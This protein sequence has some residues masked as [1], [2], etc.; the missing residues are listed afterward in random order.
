M[1]DIRSQ[2]R[3]R[4][5]PLNLA[6]AREAEV[7]EELA[8]HLQ[9]RFDEKIAAGMTEADAAGD[10]AQQIQQLTRELAEVERRQPTPP[11]LAAPRGRSVLGT[12]WQDTRFALR[13]FRSSPGVAAIV[14]LTLALGIGATTAVFSVLDVVLLRPMPY[15]DVDRIVRVLE[16]TTEGRMMSVSWPNYLDWRERNR[17]FEH[18]GISRGTTANLTGREQPERLV[19]ASVS[20]DLFSVMGVPPLYGRAFGPAED[21][22]SANRVAIISERLWRSHFGADPSV[23]GTNVSLDGQMYALVG[24]MPAAM[25]YP[26]RLTDLWLPIGL[27][28]AA[29]PPRGAH[30]GLTGMGKLKPGVTLTQAMADMESVALQLEQQYPDSNKN[31]RVSLAS[32]EDLMVRNIRPVLLVLLGAVGCV[33]LIGCANLAN[34]LLSRG[35]DRHREIAIRT[36]LGAERRRIVQ[37]LLTESLL[38]AF[39]GGALGAGLAWWA[40]RAF[41]ASQPSTVPRIDVVSVDGRVLLFAAALSMITG[42]VF[43]LVPALRASAP[44]L[45]H[46]IKDAS[47]GTTARSRRLR[48]ALVVVEVALAMVLLVGAGLMIRSFGKLMNIDPGF[49]AAHVI[50]GRVTLP[51]ARYPDVAAWQRF[52]RD[53]IERIQAV[54]GIDAAAVNT[55]MPLEGGA[56]ESSV[57]AEGQPRPQ[58]GRPGHSTLFQAASPDYFRTMGIPIVKGRALTARDTKDAPYVVV[59]DESFAAKLF[60]SADPIGKRIAFETRGR[61]PD[62]PPIWREVVGVVG[63]VKHHG[64]VNEPP[65]VQLYTSLDQP[66]V[67]WETRG[68]SIAVFVRSALAPP[69]V[70]S[71]LRRELAGLDR[72]VPIYD[73][74]PMNVLVALHVE[75]QRLSTMLLAGLGGLALVLAIV[76][77]YGVLSYAVA[78]RTQEL[79]IRMALGASRAGVLALVIRHGVLLALAGIAI[80]AAASYGLTRFLGALLFEVSPQDPATFVALAVLLALAAL[81]ASAVPALRATRVNPIEALRAE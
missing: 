67:Y 78:R 69:V 31:N 74:R 18:L 23:V 19:A 25:R 53:L 20:S 14:L 11:P 61:G 73:V 12:V 43:G 56:S 35:E 54:P 68:P 58:A 81:A 4:L 26:S 9:Q 80:G 5:A 29:M 52:N 10:A 76:G 44:N 13:S 34:L 37:Q 62:A 46:T 70:A 79:G 63:H 64:L 49:D 28:V 7:M 24:V 2:L 1:R 71:A 75:Q 30:P 17:V 51:A 38:L 72:D 15:Q 48:S 65:F 77:I 50:A 21:V 36:A 6:P 22:A 16:Q 42:I 55:A 60:P 39:T 8:Q 40:V 47:R 27:S 41:V 32:Y 33:L 3:R 66:P 57:F 59:I 45:V